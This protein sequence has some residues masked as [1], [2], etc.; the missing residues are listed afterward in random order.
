MRARR[1]RFIWPA[2]RPGPPGPRDRGSERDASQQ[3]RVAAVGA[4]V[5]VPGCV[6]LSTTGILDTYRSQVVDDVSQLT[7]AVFAAWC[8]GWTLLR[9]R[10]AG[11][12]PD[13]WRWRAL[14]LVGV[15]GWAF[16][17][18]VWSLYQLVAGRPLP[19]P[20]LA[21]VGYFALPVFAVPAVLALPMTTSPRPA[22]PAEL[23]VGDRRTRLLL[24]LDA[25]VI[26]CSLFLLT[27]STTLGAAVHSKAP[28]TATF[29]VAV[30]Y[31]I[32]DLIMAVIVLLIAVFRRPHHPQVLVLLGAGLVALSVSD[33]LFLY[34]VSVRAGAMPPPYNVG[35]VAGPVLIGLAALAPEPESRARPGGGQTWAATWFV[36][37]PYLPLTAIGL[38]VVAQQGTGSTMDG[39][40]AYGLVVLVGLVVVRQLL[41]LL[42]NME[43][44]RRV[45]QG[46]DQLHHQAFH[47]WLTGLPNRAL[48]R[49]RLEQALERHRRGGHRLA[50]LFCDL[51]DFKGVN[52]TLGHAAG[53]E[54][55]TVTAQR[56]RSSVRASD[57]VAR[58][59]GDEFAIVLDDDGMSPL[60]T[61]ERVL[62]ALERPVM[63]A[64]RHLS[65]RASAGLVV[66]EPGEHPVTAE[67]LLHQAD[68]A[69]YRAKRSGKGRLVQHSL[70]PVGGSPAGDLRTQL[71]RLL[72]PEAG[73]GR[74][75]DRRVDGRVDATARTDAESD[76]R[77]GPLDL[78]YQPIVR[79]PGGGAVAVE[80]LLRW[81]SPGSAPVPPQTVVEVAE[82][83][84]L[85]GRLQARIL[86]QACRDLAG[87][88]AS[89]PSQVAVH[90][91]V[92]PSLVTD[93][94]LVAQVRAALD[95]HTLPGEAL[96]L[97]V[98][99]TGRIR[100]LPAAARVL[101]GVRRLGVRVA[102]DDF[103]SGQ[104]TLTHLL[105][106]PI[107]ILKLDPSLTADAAG[108]GRTE[109]GRP[110]GPTAGVDRAV[111]V[112]AG[113]VQMA[114]R[115][116]I[117]LVAEG[118]EAPEQAARL[119]A[120][121][122]DLGQG[123]LF[124]RPLPLD[125]LRLAGLLGRGGTGRATPSAI[126]PLREP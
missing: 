40:E 64:G 75:L 99:E 65:P 6:L 102:L 17:Q 92:P 78:V 33:S 115:L 66:V 86:G 111:A 73:A 68:A 44:L 43:L 123:Y 118:L 103:G 82:A 69:M 31:P 113:A 14:L 35:F 84:G 121:G 95:E 18:A 57:T 90:V 60:T 13:T 91:N 15:T 47:D 87:V 38:L 62:A 61:G 37:L 10:R 55:L 63:L 125:E 53:D 29:A 19:S 109:Q 20:S 72:A 98:T 106:L 36:L 110:A 49:D 39:T 85:V 120:L 58:L 3:L 116:R 54:L 26:V 9:D 96:V 56:L 100:D 4:A 74:A 93:G 16:G 59:G 112:S 23:T 12:G 22:P 46:Q 8:C 34:L 94:A 104:S 45:R 70:G 67:A 105:R 28:T 42:E 108:G 5:A 41:T 2:H 117:P 32:T 114:H 83:A 30:A 119:V 76:G 77:T 79:L 89:L 51:D 24:A 11:R 7:A 88:R 27:W 21:D 97:E 101:E 50:M 126:A 1:R 124:S 81:R 107:D 48:F 25:Q 80:A 71:S 52:D 122:C